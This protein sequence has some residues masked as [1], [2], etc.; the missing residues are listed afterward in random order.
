MARLENLLGAQSLVLAD[1]LLAGARE[2]VGSEVSG[3]ECAALVTL[4]AHPGRTVGWLGDVLGLTSSGITRLV[5]R[6]TSGGWVRRSPGSDA[7]RRQLELTSAGRARAQLLLDGRQVRLSRAVEGFSSTER[8]SLE[9]LLDKMVS[10]LADDRLTALRACR[11][12][13][14]AAC[15]DAGHEC[16]LQH[17][18]RDD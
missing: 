7:R 14:R 13:D 6:L 5:E 10:A 1:W 2:S 9:A 17:T 18:V 12:C 11:M 16:P 8:A 15:Q 4:L 3:S